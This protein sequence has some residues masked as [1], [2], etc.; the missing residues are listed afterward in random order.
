MLK[1]K[2]LTLYYIYEL[3]SSQHKQGFKRQHQYDCYNSWFPTWRV[4]KNLEQAHE[5]WI[6]IN[7]HEKS[8]STMNFDYT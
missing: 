6:K 5:K 4:P 7:R 3:F 8:T 1:E 2:N